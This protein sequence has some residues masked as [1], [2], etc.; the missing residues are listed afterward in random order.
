M[1]AGARIKKLFN[2]NYSFMEFAYRMFQ[3]RSM[4]KIYIKAEN[5]KKNKSPAKRITAIAYDGLSQNTHPSVIYQYGEYVLAA[6][7]FPFSDALKEN[8]CIYTSDDGIDFLIKGNQP[9]ALPTAESYLSDPE[10]LFKDGRYLLYYRE[11]LYKEKITKIYKR[12]SK[13]LTDWTKPETIFETTESF[14]SPSVLSHNGTD[15]VYAVNICQ[16]GS[17]L[18]RYTE[19]DG[20]IRSDYEVLTVEGLPEGKILWHIDIEIIDGKFIAVFTL[21]TDKNGK[22]SKIYFATGNN[23]GSKWEI[24]KKIDLC[25]KEEKY[26]KSIYKASIL[27]IEKTIKIFVAAMNKKNAWHIYTIDFTEDFYE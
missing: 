3:K 20:K 19:K 27:D 13:D 16:E 4:P 21:S 24:V 22:N 5:N 6:S 23:D 14:L 25:Q 26:F 12:C 9:L 8:P 11:S 18:C 7:P 17:K 15:Y 10:I 1:G 2:G